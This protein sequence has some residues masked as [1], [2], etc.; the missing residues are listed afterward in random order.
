MS[1]RIEWPDWLA[2]DLTQDVTDIHISLSHV[3]RVQL[4]VSHQLR[5]LV[6]SE[7]SLTAFVHR[8]HWACG[9]VSLDTQS[10][11]H[12]QVMI[13]EISVRVSSMV[14]MGGV[15]ICMRLQHPH[16]H[17]ISQSFDPIS[18]WSGCHMIC[19]LTGSGK[20][21]EAYRRLMALGLDHAVL[22][23][24]DPPEVCLPHCAQIEWQGGVMSKD[25]LKVVLRH[26]PD[27]IFM[28]EVRDRSALDLLRNWMLTGHACLATIHA[29][30]ADEAWQRLCY[31]GF[32]THATHMI[33]QI[34]LME[35]FQAQTYVYQGRWTK[36]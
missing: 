13:D 27:V 8:L 17:T 20:T 24:E 19:G 2:S 26:D 28:G 22:T 12:A 3:A 21:T 6:V 9:F 23:I 16:M 15:R 33:S 5:S 36:M 30:S 14:V 7:K 10:Y 25:L 18:L 1:K 34:T 4:R 29:S 32:P 31:L 35:A 11:H